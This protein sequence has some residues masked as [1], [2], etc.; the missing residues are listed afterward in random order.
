MKLPNHG[1]TLMLLLGLAIG[2][3]KAREP[4]G[5]V[6]GGAVKPATVVVGWRT[7]GTGEYPDAKAATTFSETDNVVWKTP[8]PG[9]S[10]ATPVITGNRIFVC[11]EPTTLIC[12]AKDSGAILWQKANSYG[13]VEGAAGNFPPTH[14]DNGQATPTPV[15]DGRYVYVLFGTGVAACYDLDGNRQWATFLEKSTD[16]WGHSASPVLSGGTLIVHILSV[17]GLDSG[18]GKVKWRT[19]ASPKWGSP[20]L[21]NIGGQDVVITPYSGDVIRVSDGRKL[22]SGIARLQYATP[23]V[24]GDTVYF[25]E[26]IARKVRLRPAGD[27]VKAET[28]WTAKI[29]GSRH[30]SSAVVDNGLIYAASREG[31]FAVIDDETGDVLLQERLN[32]GGGKNSV[33]S[34][35]VLGGNYLYIGSV[36]GVTVVLEPG[37]AF[38]EVARNRIEGYRSSPVFDGDRMYVRTFRHLYCIGT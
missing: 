6:P 32:I 17:A 12:V 13:E 20:A 28:L 34:S 5:A 37:R 3:C 24:D 10:N 22:A 2:D 9:T 8:L 27:G 18:S 19:P 38:E 14:G 25:I 4:E 23:V 29:K 15:T 16:H 30:Y 26:K 36:G 1:I 33:Y 7:D 35:L 11:S 21:A 31:H